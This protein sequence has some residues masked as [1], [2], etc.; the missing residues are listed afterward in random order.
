MDSLHLVISPARQALLHHPAVV[1][2]D[3]GDTNC[4]DD[5]V[6]P[7]C[8]RATALQSQLHLPTTATAMPGAFARPTGKG[9][10]S[11]TPMGKS[12][13]GC[14]HTCRVDCRNRASRCYPNAAEKRRELQTRLAKAEQGTR[15]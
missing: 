10:S 11:Q 15:F 8:L 3:D 7:R 6:T 1:P 2:G 9:L 14:Q 12:S 4:G 5:D 13:S